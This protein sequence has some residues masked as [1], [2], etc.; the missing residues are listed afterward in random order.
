MKQKISGTNLDE[1]A[2]SARDEERALAHELVADLVKQDFPEERARELLLKV[3]PR[4]A[5]YF[6]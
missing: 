6:D 3:E 5:Q 1:K 2:A 4:M